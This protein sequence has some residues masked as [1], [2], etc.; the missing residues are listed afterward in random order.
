MVAPFLTHAV[1]YAYKIIVDLEKKCLTD[2]N[3]SG[4]RSREF[5]GLPKRVLG[6]PLLKPK[7]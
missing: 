4:F 6:T 3:Y 1:E 7:I 5:R 2:Y